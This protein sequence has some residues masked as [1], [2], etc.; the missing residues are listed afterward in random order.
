M[1]EGRNTEK[2]WYQKPE[3]LFTILAFVLVQGVT[4]WKS[5][6]NQASQGAVQ[7]RDFEDFKQKFIGFQQDVLKQ[8]AELRS[9]Q[10]MWQDEQRKAWQ[11]EHDSNS[12][13]KSQYGHL[14]DAVKDEKATIQELEKKFEASE[15]RQSDYNF[16]LSGR[17]SRVEKP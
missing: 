1:T 11:A 12:E 8:I 4:Y 7:A 2:R 5:S 6:V 9:S 17:L 14:E 13:L 15:K 16:N 10:T 3:F